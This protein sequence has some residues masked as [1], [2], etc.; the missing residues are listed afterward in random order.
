M[1][2]QTVA[3]GIRLTQRDIEAVQKCQDHYG[4]GNFSNAVRFII[5]EWERLTRDNHNGKDTKDA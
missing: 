1:D 4:F 3:R 5:R 2:E